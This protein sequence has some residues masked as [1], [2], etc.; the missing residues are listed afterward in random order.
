[1]LNPDVE[2]ELAATNFTIKAL[3]VYWAAALRA[4]RVS[5]STLDGNPGY[6]FMEMVRDREILRFDRLLHGDP[7]VVSTSGE[8]AVMLDGVSRRFDA[9]KPRAFPKAERVALDLIMEMSAPAAAAAPERPVAVVLPG[10]AI[11]T[12]TLSLDFYSRLGIGQIEEIGS[13]ARMMAEINESFQTSVD[14]LYD[15]LYT[16]KAWLGYPR[17]G[18]LGILHP[19]LGQ[20][21]RCSW[22]LK[23]VLDRDYALTRDQIE[24]DAGVYQSGGFRGVNYDGLIVRSSGE[25][26]APAAHAQIHSS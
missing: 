15:Q 26:E 6:G 9:I 3:P 7:V 18:S 5:L 16:L 21:V 1:M 10:S 22:D 2:R 19:S 12:L 13:C 24:R 4:A 20:N 25:F 11:P 17:N 23:K 14:S 8:L